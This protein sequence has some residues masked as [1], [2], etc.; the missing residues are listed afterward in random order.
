M[1]RLQD[2]ARETESEIGTTADADTGI[3]A[4]VVIG[5]DE[6]RMHV[7][8][9]NYWVSLLDGRSYPS[10]ED[11]DL[12]NATDFGPQSVLLDFTHAGEDPAIAWLGEKLRAECDLSDSV[13]SVVSEVPSRS[14]LSR[15]TDHHLQIIANR[16][17][18]GFEAEF[19]NARG[20]NTMYRGILLP[21]S[22]DND[23]IDFIYGVINWK[24]IAG[25]VEVDAI[26]REM[27]AS[28]ATVPSR[29]VV[30]VWAD[31]P[32]RLEQAAKDA[33]AVEESVEE[34]IDATPPG[35][36]E[37]LG[38]WL[39]AARANADVA[40]TADTRSRGALYRALSG[41]Y[42]FALVAEQRADEYAALLRESKIGSQAR[43]PM[44]P[45][46]KLVFGASYDKTRLT[47]FA[48]AMSFAH[49]RELPAGGMKLFLENFP[50][51]LKAIVAAERRERRPEGKEAKP[52]TTRERARELPEQAYLTLS[53]N[54]EF[55]IMVA[56]RVDADRVAI[57]GVV[58]DDKPLLD[59]ALRHVVE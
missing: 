57:I 4:P 35:E 45:V 11:I 49:R 29:P 42:D 6:R 40:L 23:T 17:P 59:R 54:D 25:E 51:G 16:A 10:V 3:D 18:I 5:T 12:D 15:L 27:R 26:E 46:A 44:T 56:R 34:D 2:F 7:R 22:S 52:D 41:A 9:Y 24:E 58:G 48:A 55:V 19:Q 28:V 37:T 43:A 39:A 33:A 8:A 36:G 14:L 47:E 20:N 31:G 1:D 50:G 32:S 53:G 38:D 13:A 21:F 30:P